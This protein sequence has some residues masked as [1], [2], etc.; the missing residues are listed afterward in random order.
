M[1]YDLEEALLA[2]YDGISWLDE[3]DFVIDADAPV[4]G[5]I[6]SPSQISDEDEFA[7]SH[8]D[9]LSWNVDEELDIETNLR[10]SSSVPE[11][12]QLSAPPIYMKEEETDKKKMPSKIVLATRLFH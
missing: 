3:E 7:A 10:C 11:I 1:K 2:E 5:G 12:Q 8:A 6:L 9:L 4:S